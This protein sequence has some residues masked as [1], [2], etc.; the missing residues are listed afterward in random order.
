M[1]EKGKN[2]IDI[3]YFRNYGSWSFNGQLEVSPSVDYIILSTTNGMVN[4]WRFNFLHNQLELHLFPPKSNYVTILEKNIN[5][6]FINSP[7][8]TQPIDLKI[9]KYTFLDKAKNEKAAN[10]VVFPG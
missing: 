8:Q 5:T 1:T 3:V 10:L 7:H 2:K 9:V 4:I 6:S